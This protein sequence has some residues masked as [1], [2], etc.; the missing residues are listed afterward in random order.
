MYTDYQMNYQK[1]PVNRARKSKLNR[2]R[3][4]ANPDIFFNYWYKSKYNI[5]L[6]EYNSMFIK[7]GG[8]CKICDK[9]QDSL[10]KRLCVDHDHTTGKVRGL[11]CI[12]CNSGIGKLGDDPVLVKKALDYL[13][14]NYSINQ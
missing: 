14:N 11:L 5:S 8:R 1:D 6:D 3:R 9:H 10:S 7:Q 12:N 13:S 2:E 4:E